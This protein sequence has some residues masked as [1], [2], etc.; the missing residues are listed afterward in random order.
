[1]CLCRVSQQVSSL[2][3]C[4]RKLSLNLLV[5]NRVLLN[6]LPNSR[7]VNRLQFGQ[8]EPEDALHPP[9]LL[10]ATL[11]TILGGEMLVEIT[12]QVEADRPTLK[13]QSLK[14][15]NYS[16]YSNEKG[17]PYLSQQ[18]GWLQECARFGSTTYALLAA[19]IP[20]QECCWVPTSP[21]S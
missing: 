8:P 5:L 12:L 19:L 15:V 20:V 13:R 9:L 17:G 21:L 2:M 11:C 4:W 7:I 14:D 1:M 6:H 16:L 18:H 3:A 10:Y